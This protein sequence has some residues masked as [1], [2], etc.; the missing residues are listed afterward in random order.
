MTCASGTVAAFGPMSSGD[1]CGIASAPGEPAN[2]VERLCASVT[3]GS[4]TC[5]IEAFFYAS[6]AG[7]YPIGQ[8]ATIACVDGVLKL[9]RPALS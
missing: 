2:N 7:K 5:E 9:I 4:F 1:L 3:V 6:L 8:P